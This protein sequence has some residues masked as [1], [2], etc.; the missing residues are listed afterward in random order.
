MASPASRNFATSFSFPALASKRANSATVYIVF[1]HGLRFSSGQDSF[2]ISTLPSIRRRSV[3]RAGRH[4]RLS[5]SRGFWD[6]R[7]FLRY[8]ASLR[9]AGCG[10][11]L[12]SRRGSH[13]AV[14]RPIPDV[15]AAD[16]TLQFCTSIHGQ[17]HPL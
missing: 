13:G 14:G 17:S 11:Q 3:R 1:L 15:T 4:S 16:S 5:S 8:D 7:R 12:E 2:Y 10:T 9:K 6:V